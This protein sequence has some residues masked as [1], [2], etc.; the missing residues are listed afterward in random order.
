MDVSTE[1]STTPTI[2]AQDISG[3]ASTTPATPPKDDDGEPS[4]KPTTP[5]TTPKPSNFGKYGVLAFAVSLSLAFLLLYAILMIVFM[6]RI[7][8]RRRAVSQSDPEAQ[9]YKK[10]NSDGLEAPMTMTSNDTTLSDNEAGDAKEKKDGDKS[11]TTESENENATAGDEGRENTDENTGQT[12]ADDK[13]TEEKADV[14]Q[15][16]KADGKQ[17]PQQDS[18]QKPDGQNPPAPTTPAPTTPAPTTP[19]PTTPDPTT[20]A[21][22]P[23]PSLLSSILNENFVGHDQPTPGPDH[24]G[25]PPDQDTS[26]LL[27]PP[28]SDSQL[29]VIDFTFDVRPLTTPDVTQSDE[30]DV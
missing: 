8:A 5:C 27:P 24:S 28:P 3:E 7:L 14:K 29:P 21:P 22:G 10:R 15:D 16:D 11:T 1:V 9:H 30:V 26:D 17:D 25:P 13:N 19:A 6:P 2:T 4:T 23:D 20:P 18:T 12:K